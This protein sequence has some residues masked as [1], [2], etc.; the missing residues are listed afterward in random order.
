M[1]IS[2]K[3][4][5]I[6]CMVISLIG[7]GALFA[8][9]A[10]MEPVRVSVQEAAN[11]IALNGGT[12]DVKIAGFV[13]SVVIGRNFATVELAALQTVEATS[14]DTNYISNLNLKRFQEVE[15]YGE[16]RDYRGRQSFIVSKIK[17]QNST[18]ICDVNLG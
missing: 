17:V 2:E 10:V 8:V 5:I 12:T 9:S 4:L 15:I 13:N 11:G 3:G 7:I 18:S 14:F 6:F 1:I 16:M